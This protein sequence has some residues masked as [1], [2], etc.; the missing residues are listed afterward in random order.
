MK[1]RFLVAW[2]ALA[3]LQTAVLA[4][5]TVI[6]M[7][8][9]APKDSPWH[10]ILLKIGEKWRDSTAGRVKLIVY[11]GGKLGD[12]PS[13]VNKMRIGQIQAAALSAGLGDIEP[14]VKCLQL[15]M[16]FRN[17]EELD[18]VRDRMSPRLEKMIEGRGFI[19]LNWGDVGWVY[20]FTTKPAL[21]MDEMRRLKLF[22]WAG[23]NEVLQLWKAN[24][25]NAI[26]LAATD[27][28]SGLTTGL[29]E[30]LPTAALYAELNQTYKI[31]NYMNDIR[32]AP[33]LGA[34]VIYKPAWERMAEGD[35]KAMMEAARM[36][37]ENLRGKIRQMGEEAIAAMREDKQGK[38]KV[39]HADDATVNEWRQQCEAVYPKL[40][41]KM[42]PA[43]LFDEVVRLRDEYRA[44]PAGAGKAAPGTS[45]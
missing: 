30:A 12:E 45:R 31:A 22:T 3:A 40:R 35:R 34:T 28:G 8:T 5:T 29:I 9:L 11:E 19:V 16:M 15:P 39:L 26:P 43:D 2:L 42:V 14:A 6:R 7:G 27:I 41:G 10:H 18:Y 38:F 21:H 44:R 32:W 13:V 36:E 1:S 23:D 33:F 37:S 17:Y 24:G 4:Q 25:F 20:F